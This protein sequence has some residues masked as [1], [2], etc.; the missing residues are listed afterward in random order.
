MSKSDEQREAD[1][2]A[3]TAWQNDPRII[4][5]EKRRRETEKL[6]ETISVLLLDDIKTKNVAIS[7]QSFNDEDVQ[8]VLN[9]LAMKI[10]S[11][12][13][14]PIKARKQLITEDC[15]RFVVTY[16]VQ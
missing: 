16:L 9:T 14:I 8:P 10:Q 15:T 11:D 2:K 12:N 3:T 7:V 13:G 1:Y 6:A 5:N 4:A